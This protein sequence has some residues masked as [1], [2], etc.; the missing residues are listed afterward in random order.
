M[1]TGV[2]KSRA[3]TASHFIRFGAI[4]ASFNAT[5]T[6]QPKPM[7]TSRSAGPSRLS[8][9]HGAKRQ[10]LGNTAGHPAPAWHPKHL[11]GVVPPPP[12]RSQG[13]TEAPGSKIIMSDLPHDVKEAEIEV[14]VVLVCG[15][16]TR[17]ADL[18]VHRIL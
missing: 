13:H 3:K 15:R 16:L 17:D 10:V 4:T 5:P 1:Q 2:I 8:S 9:Y 7:Q 12:K 14:R 18:C 6:N 11:N